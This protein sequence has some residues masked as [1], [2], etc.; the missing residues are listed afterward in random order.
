MF[1]TQN[2]MLAVCTVASRGTSDVG[3]NVTFMILI[4][5]LNVKIQC[6]SVKVVLKRRVLSLSA[7]QPLGKCNLKAISGLL[8][9]SF[10]LGLFWGLEI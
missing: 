7:H 6:V 3:S 8:G 5:H 9:I 10:N 2:S 4:P 1:Q